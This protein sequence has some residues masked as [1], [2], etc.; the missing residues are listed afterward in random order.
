MPERLSIDTDGTG[1]KGK[2]LKK[3]FFPQLDSEKDLKEQFYPRLGRS[4]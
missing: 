4:E 2:R 1:E 3:Q